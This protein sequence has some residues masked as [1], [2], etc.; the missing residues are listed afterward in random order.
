MK[1]LVITLQS[2]EVR[3]ILIQEK[4]T[5]RIHK[6]DFLVVSLSD[7]EVIISSINFNN[8]ILKNNLQTKLGHICL[9]PLTKDSEKSK[10]N[11]TIYELASNVS[12]V[13]IE[14][15]IVD[16]TL[17]K[18]ERAKSAGLGSDAEIDSNLFKKVFCC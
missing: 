15:A 1:E 9:E 10:I 16:L 18:I 14:Q 3:N 13:S 2:G 7:E 11:V 6:I 5:F 17:E 8:I 4:E 12:D